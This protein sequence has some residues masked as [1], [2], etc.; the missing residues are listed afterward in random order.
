MF[1][2]F[3]RNFYELLVDQPNKIKLKKFKIDKIKHIL[4]RFDQN[5]LDV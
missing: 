1:K 4:D 3:K 5:V 2:D